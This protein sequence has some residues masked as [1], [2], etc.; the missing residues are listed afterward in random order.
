MIYVVQVGSEWVF[1]SVASNSK[2]GTSERIREKMVKIGEKARAAVDEQTF[3]EEVDFTA[4]A[5]EGPRS[6]KRS[7]NL[8]MI[9]LI[10][11]K[12]RL[13]FAGWLSNSWLLFKRGREKL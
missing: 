5:D 4:I 9:K 1:E 12:N 3:Q 6:E 2:L 13:N 11:K 7:V 8:V 10:W